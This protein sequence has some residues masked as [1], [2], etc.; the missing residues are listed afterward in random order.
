MAAACRRSKCWSF[1]GS[2]V[3]KKFVMGAT[4]LMLSG[5]VLMH[6]LGNMIIIFKGPDAYNLYGH[7]MTTN[8]LYPIVG[9]GLLAV[10]ILHILMA[11]W[12]TK[13]NKAARPLGY[14]AGATN[15]EKRATLASRTMFY[16]GSILAAF[17]ALH[18]ATFKYGANYSTFVGNVEVRDLA[19]LFFEVFQSPVYVTWYIFSLIMIAIH[20]KH[21]FAAAFQSVGFWHPKYTPA[22]KCFALFYAIVVAAGFISQPLYAFFL[23]R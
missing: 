15:G 8:P 11:I 10:F 3:G 13:D 18:L 17:L 4:G 12:I 14:S 7:A 2:S 20:L 21:G 6:M 5:F 16:S 19:K 9:P 22:L 1:I 23:H